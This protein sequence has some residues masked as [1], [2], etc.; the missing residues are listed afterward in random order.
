MRDD[1]NDDDDDMRRIK[2]FNDNKNIKVLNIFLTIV[3][4]RNYE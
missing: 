2:K 4:D 1:D 3:S